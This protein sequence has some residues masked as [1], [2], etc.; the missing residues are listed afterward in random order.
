M[1]KH[2]ILLLHF[3]FLYF[4]PLLT[5]SPQTSFWGKLLGTNVDCYTILKKQTLPDHPWLAWFVIRS[6]TKQKHLQDLWYQVQKETYQN[7]E[8]S[9]SIAL[10]VCYILFLFFI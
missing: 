7:A 5:S 8:L 2:K 4:Q 9:P 6:E 10:K 1:F 3:F